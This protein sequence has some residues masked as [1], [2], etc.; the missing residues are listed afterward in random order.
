VSA[1]GRKLAVPKPFAPDA[2]LR[3]DSLILPLESFAWTTD[4]DVDDVALT[5]QKNAIIRFVSRSNRSRL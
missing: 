1:E 4:S 2:R 3:S 5:R